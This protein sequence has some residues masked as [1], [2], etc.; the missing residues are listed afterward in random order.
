MC[1]EDSLDQSKLGI[2]IIFGSYTL[3]DAIAPWSALVKRIRFLSS[4]KQADLA[5]E[6]G[7]DQCSVSRWERGTHLPD[8][9][10][11][12][13]LRDM[14]RRLEPTIDTSFV[15]QAP[16]IVIVSRMEKVGFVSAMSPAAAAAYR[17]NPPETRDLLIY[18]ITSDS[19][20]AFL[21]AIDSTPAWRNGEIAMWNVVLRRLDGNWAQFTGSPIGSTGF[22]MCIGAAVPPP[23]Q[24]TDK[25]YLLTLN[26]F[27]ELCN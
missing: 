12:K 20:R 25:D 19:K 6:L 24:C 16:A 18:D 1:T 2:E 11:Q 14:L 17:L 27:D 5:K 3:N 8:V 15:E 21:E 7:V 22:F 10:V 4:L 23:S 26:P 13:R 9:L